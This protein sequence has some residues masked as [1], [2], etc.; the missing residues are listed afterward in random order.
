MEIVEPSLIPSFWISG[1]PEYPATFPVFPRLSPPFIHHSPN[2]PARVVGDI[3]RTVRPHGHAHWA[4]LRSRG[5]LLPEAVRERLV[6][7][8]RLAVLEGHERDPVARLG[9]RRAVP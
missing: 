6:A 5:V 4:V 8:H 9:E 7:A 3:Q 1:F 2:R